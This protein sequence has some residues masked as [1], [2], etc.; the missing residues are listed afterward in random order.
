VE[1]W[2]ERAW[3][4]IVPQIQSERSKMLWTVGFLTLHHIL[5]PAQKKQKSQGEMSGEYGG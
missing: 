4:Q 5:A 1:Y 3:I 2:D